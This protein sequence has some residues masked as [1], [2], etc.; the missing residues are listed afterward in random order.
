MPRDFYS[1]STDFISFCNFSDLPILV[2]NQASSTSAP[3]ESPC[4]QE[5]N[6]E[7]TSPFP[8]PPNS[9]VD[10]SGGGLLETNAPFAPEL[11][12]SVLDITNSSFAEIA[13]QMTGEATSDT[14]GYNNDDSQ[15]EGII[16][17]FLPVYFVRCSPEHG[18]LCSHFIF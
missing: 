18:F 9:S 13:K 17:F 3:L 5:D 7:R 6:P 12:S 14:D 8:A 4:S 16:P 1:P 15:S 2:Q 11:S 10:P